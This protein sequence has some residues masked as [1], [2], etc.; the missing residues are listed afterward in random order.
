[1]PL[2]NHSIVSY[3]NSKISS[4]DVNTLKKTLVKLLSETFCEQIV[5]I[6]QNKS[7]TNKGFVEALLQRIK[8]L[9]QL[10]RV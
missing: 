6:G 2:A 5:A 9:V 7:G 10:N 8:R 1:M 4:E 3:A